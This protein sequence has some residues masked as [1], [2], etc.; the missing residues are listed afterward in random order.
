M[1]RSKIFDPIKPEKME[2]WKYPK[3]EINLLEIQ[4]T[5][6]KYIMCNNVI[7]K[8]AARHGGI[9]LV[10]G[11]RVQFYSTHWLAALKLRCRV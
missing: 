7:I 8:H 3:L 4:I 1:R 9:G 2:M 6:N 11:I 5:N 10:L